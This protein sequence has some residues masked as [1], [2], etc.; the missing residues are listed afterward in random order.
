MGNEPSKKN[1]PAKSGYPGQG[2]QGCGIS[3]LS[4]SNFRPNLRFPK[5][6]KNPFLNDKIVF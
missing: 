5:L 4:V 1:T 2:K 3:S 6:K